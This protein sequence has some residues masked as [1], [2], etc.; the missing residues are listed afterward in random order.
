[1]V[2]FLLSLGFEARLFRTISTKR[3]FC[4]QL[5]A[6]VTTSLACLS[7]LVHLWM[8]FRRKASPHTPYYPTQSLGC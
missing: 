2:R 5:E 6:N 3:L 4:M 1:M 7:S 8:W